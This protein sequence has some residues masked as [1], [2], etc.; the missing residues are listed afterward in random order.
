MPDKPVAEAAGPKVDTLNYAGVGMQGDHVN[1]MF[2]AR[3]QIMDKEQALVL[4]AYLVSLA[5]PG[6]ERWAVVLKAVKNT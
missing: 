1:V 2:P 6:G 4:A 3:L 5:D